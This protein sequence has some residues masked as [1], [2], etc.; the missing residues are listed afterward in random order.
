MRIGRIVIRS[1]ADVAT[2]GGG[3][4]QHEAP[5]DPNGHARIGIAERTL[6]RPPH[7]GR[8]S[9]STSKTRVERP[10][11]AGGPHDDADRSGRFRSLAKTDTSACRLLL[12]S[13]TQRGKIG[14]S[15]STPSCEWIQ[16]NRPRF[17]HHW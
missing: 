1:K 3:R 9:A 16:D 8:Q 17:Q 14:D 7:F 6:I 11:A 12:P 10:Q 4:W 2:R 15:D 5:K 13:S